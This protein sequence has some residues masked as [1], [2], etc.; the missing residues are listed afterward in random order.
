M[1]PL[2]DFDT[3]FIDN[4][5]PT[6]RI[7][8]DRHPAYYV[9]SVGVWLLTRYDTVASANDPSVWSSREGN[10]FPVD[11]PQRVGN[12]LGTTDPPQHT[13]LRR[14]VMKAFTPR[15]IAALEPV[16]RSYARELLEPLREAKEFDFVSAYAKPFT[17]GIVAMVLGIP[18]SDLAELTAAIDAAFT[19]DHTR[20]LEE[21]HAGRR[22]AFAYCRELIKERR[23]Q[24]QDDVI[25]GLIQAEVD[26]VRLSDDQIAV[27]SGTIL[28]AGYA[29]TEH[30]LSNLWVNLSRHPQALRELR[31]DP[32]L[33]PNAFEESIRYESAGHIFGRQTLV[34]VDVHG[35]RIPAGSRVGLCYGS[36]NR[37][38][39][40]FPDPDRFDIRRDFRQRRHLGFGI[41]PHFCLGASLARIEGRVTLQEALAVIGDYTTHVGPEHRLRIVQFRGYTSVP[42]TVL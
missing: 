40:A 13:L 16:A 21:R 24:P 18:R 34:D 36:A 23:K 31:D 10:I 33:I 30:A 42:T 5:W 22:K 38:E 3:S 37:D 2:T 11:D 41:S 25:T 27:T 28:G 32:T 17:A 19:V 8:R 4:P 26:G 35:T 39:R 1:I 14:L 12:T 9:E 6:Y 15:R 29:S 20:P 7:L